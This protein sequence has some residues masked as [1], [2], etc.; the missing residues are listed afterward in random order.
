MGNLNKKIEDDD[1]NAK[2]KGTMYWKSQI[3]YMED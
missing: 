1:K 3:D 2:K